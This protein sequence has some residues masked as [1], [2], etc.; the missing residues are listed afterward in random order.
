MLPLL[1]THCIIHNDLTTSNFIVDNG[2]LVLLDFGLSYYSAR[3][4][5]Q[6]VDIRSI[7]TNY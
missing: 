7:K 6:A 5:N 4:E 2:E 3:I 1:H